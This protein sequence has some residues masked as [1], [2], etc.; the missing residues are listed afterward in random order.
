MRWLVLALILIFQGSAPA[1]ATVI[2]AEAKRWQRELTAAARESYGLNAPVSTLAAL[3]HQESTWRA[4]A[5]SSVGAQGLA[6]F[7]PATANWMPEIYP[8]L[9]TP[10]PFDP[11]WSIRAMVLYTKWLNQR[12]KSGNE[13][14]QWAFVLS[15]YNGG[16]GWVNKDK[17]LAASQG[18]NELHWFENVA[19]V[20]SGRS[21]ANFNENRTY[22]SL[23]L[24]QISPSYQAANWGRAVCAERWPQ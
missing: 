9:A 1:L 7:M 12:I 15:S 18:L 17:K 23:I 21:A 14:E 10:Q 16:L 4:N 3:I 20:N 22:P 5:I 24:L 2:P 8:H 6:Q 13:C 19:T 11:R